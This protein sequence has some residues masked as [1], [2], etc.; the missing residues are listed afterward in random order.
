MGVF[1]AVASVAHGQPTII[2]FDASA[3]KKEA[4]KPFPQFRGKS[5]SGQ[6]IEANSQYLSLD[7]KPW[8]PVMGEF[9]F[10]RFP[11]QY[12]EEELLKMKAG[13][14]QVVS[15]YVFWIHH[16]ET[17]GQFDWSGRHDLRRF[18][19]LCGKHGLYVSLR[20]GPWAHGEARNGGFPDW[21]L[22]KSPETRKNDPGY[23]KY[24]RIFYGEIGKQIK[25]QSF[26]EGG[27]I[28]DVQ[29]EN[30]YVA[31]GEYQGAAHIVELKKIARQAG[32]T[33]P[34]YTVTGWMNP[35]FPTGEALPVFA[36]YPDAFW[37]ANRG[38]L[39][40]SP[41][42]FF[43]S[44]RDD[45]EVASDLIAK[46]PTNDAEFSKY[47][48]LMAEA[49]GGMEMAY[50]RRPVVTPNDIASMLVCKVGSGANQYGY[51]M[52][53]GGTNPEGKLAHLQEEQVTGGWN[54][55]PVKSYDFQA[56][57][58]EFGQMHVSFRRLKLFH[59]F[60]QS[61]GDAL[62]PMRPVFPKEQP[63]GLEDQKMLRASLRVQGASGFV[64]V[65]NHQRSIVLP[66][67]T[68]TQFSVALP[69][70]T[71]VFPQTPIKIPSDAYFILPVNMDVGGTL[72]KYA[73][74]QP[75]LH[76][77][78]AGV[79]YHFF[80]AVPGVAPEFA[81]DAKSVNDVQASSGEVSRTAER[82]TVANLKP[83][84]AVAMKIESATHRQIRIVVLAR[85]QA[86]Q[87]WAIR[88][89]GRTQLVLTFADVFADGERLH[90]RSLAPENLY[91]A[92]FPPL[93]QSPVS[94]ARLSRGPAEGVFESYVAE[95]PRIEIS[96]AVKQT[97]EAT[98]AP[99]IK[100]KRVAEE[101]AEDGYGS[102]AQWTI[103]VPRHP[104]TNLSNVFVR[105][106]YAGDVARFYAEDKLVTDDFY[107]GLPLEIG[108]KAL[109]PD[110]WAEKLRLDVLPLRKD[111]PIY[112]PPRAWPQFVNSAQVSQLS[113]VQV[114]PEYEVTI[115]VASQDDSRQQESQR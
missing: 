97:R 58:G 62:A 33:A 42:F 71:V 25:G 85:A 107:S 110:L 10:T 20:I 41:N 47:P 63:K 53:H 18:I 59:Q 91:A 87:V 37:E 1:L 115:Q 60:L 49:G 23:L 24:V 52:F 38:E 61:Y 51:Y 66:E 39:P 79:E 13:G 5:P 48:Y 6:T 103:E 86:E 102:S 88:F 46:H 36:G 16:E 99:A 45:G 112:L 17:E 31:R 54:D 14:V 21:L 69:G 93:P 114:F 44:T 67:H 64:F 70:E 100:A 15:T 22:K 77:E 90:L 3:Q 76:L 106:K 95:V 12:W 98:A 101:P 4:P 78:D 2:H 89:G 82:I 11:E 75:M 111:A 94:S 55:L 50:H 9:H 104:N 109:N 7:G 56:P 113:G 32:I 19:E 65:N 27:P 81:F 108:L 28:I 80:V 105:V 43:T 84:T 30:E 34:I 29:I 8:F 57:L 35:E 68:A 96:P 92:F 26:N 40:P 83:G 72:L 73:T 74:A